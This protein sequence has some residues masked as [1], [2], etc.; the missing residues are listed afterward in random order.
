MITQQT[1]QQSRELSLERAR[2]LGYFVSP[3]GETIAKQR[4]RGVN[5]TERDQESTTSGAFGGG[6]ERWVGSCSGVKYSSSPVIPLR[7]HRENT[8]HQKRLY[9]LLCLLDA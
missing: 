7:K 2:L 1:Q 3:M 9:T 6:G 8:K 4:E 5:Y